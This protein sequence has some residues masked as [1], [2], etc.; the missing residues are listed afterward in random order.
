MTSPSSPENQSKRK[1]GIPAKIDFRAMAQRCIDLGLH[2]N[3]SIVAALSFLE[4]NP[5]DSQLQEYIMES[6]AEAERLEMVSPDPFRATNP[7]LHE[8]LPGAIILGRV[9]ETGMVWKITP[10][11]LTTHMLLI[12]RSGGGKSNMIFLI[13]LQLLETRRHDQTV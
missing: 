4:I 11:M 8:E 10:E 5:Y 2:K 12:A 1:A 3:P 9:P 6:I 13:L 7:T